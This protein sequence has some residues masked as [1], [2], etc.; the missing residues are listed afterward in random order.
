M[1]KMTTFLASLL[2]FL[3]WGCN[4]GASLDGLESQTKEEDMP[5]EDTPESVAIREMLA[6]KSDLEYNWV[7]DYSLEEGKSYTILF[8]FLS[9]SSV[10]T[11][12]PQSDNE[13]HEALYKVTSDSEGREILRFDGPTML[14][15][16]FIEEIYR[17]T[18]LSVKATNES[19]LSCT[20]LRNGKNLTLRH[21]TEADINKLGEK[22]IWVILQ[23]KNAMKSVL[24]DASDNFVLR[25]FLDK[26]TREINFTWIDKNSQQAVH[27]KKPFTIE[28]TS[29]SY[30]LTWET[31]KING[32]DFKSLLYSLNDEKVAF[33]VPEL[34]FREGI[35][36]TPD[37][38]N[39]NAN[40]YN[41]GGSSRTG[42]AS[43][44]LWECLKSNK[45]ETIYFY[46]YADDIPLN[47]KAYLADGST[48]TY[49]I[50]NDYTPDP[51]TA[52]YDTEDDWVRFYRSEQGDF[53]KPL[54]AQ[55][56][57]YTIQD[58]AEELKPFIDFYF[59]EA[60]L[61]VIDASDVRGRAFYLISRNTSEWVKVRRDMIPEDSPFENHFPKPVKAGIASYG[62]AL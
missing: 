46:Q 50:V 30:T 32:R 8:N 58:A 21:A 22:R 4:D 60:G 57:A 44:T 47:I 27:Q 18:A 34:S 31:V 48:G 43:P 1:K 37:F 53:L 40:H 2:V 5:T 14:S 59:D 7:A 13:K 6:Y 36:A 24:R 12:A 26:T 20:G 17:E 62:T 28:I 61:Y 35:K 16:P 9:D 15:D 51:K 3:A 39:G 23:K 42:S 54:S 19:E 55:N 56:E 10:S 11:D 38:V 33:N 52:R 45:F 41:L 49:L 25:Y 29:D